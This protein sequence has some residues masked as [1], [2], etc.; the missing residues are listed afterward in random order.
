MDKTTD[1]VPEKVRFLNI[2]PQRPLKERKKETTKKRETKETWK[3]DLW[4][5]NLQHGEFYYDY[6]KKGIRG[7]ETKNYLK[8]VLMRL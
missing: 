1:E 2:E 6:T 4:I 7:R 8:T 3:Q 5:I